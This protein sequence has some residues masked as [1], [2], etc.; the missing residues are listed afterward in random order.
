MTFSRNYAQILLFIYGI[1]QVSHLIP[2]N[3]WGFASGSVVLCIQKK[4]I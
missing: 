4:S 2:D 1:E 3:G